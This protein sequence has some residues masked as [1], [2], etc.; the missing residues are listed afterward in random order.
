M[1]EQKMKDKL[2]DD[3]KLLWIG[4]PGSRK[5]MDSPDKTKIIIS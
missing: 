1:I 2:R 3:E 4:K 5:L